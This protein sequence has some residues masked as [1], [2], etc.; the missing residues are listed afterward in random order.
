MPDAIILRPSIVFGPEDDFFN[1]FAALARMSPVLP[2]IGGGTTRFQPV[3]A[4][5]VADAVACAVE[6]RARAGTTYELGGPDV[7]TFK[8]LM[9]FVLAT[10]QRRR[11]LVPVPFP[12]ARLKAS[13]LQFLPKPPLTPDQVELLRSDNV[14][15]QAAADQG[16]TLQGLG[17]EPSG[18]A[19]I[20]PT[21]L[22]RFRRTGEF[23]KRPA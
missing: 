17:I 11:L 19:G 22:W 2:L 21:Y 8:E 13:V 18:I 1:R 20:V 15:S 23:S 6:G 5:D 10:I 9:E 12:L 14:V 7:K 3:Y 4:G 16:R